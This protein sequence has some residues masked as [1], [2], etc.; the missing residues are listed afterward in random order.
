MASFMS[1]QLSFYGLASHA[2]DILTVS[3]IALNIYR[4]LSQT[5][6]TNYASM[7]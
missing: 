2:D 3:L 1:L 6:I 4:I 5:I 7:C